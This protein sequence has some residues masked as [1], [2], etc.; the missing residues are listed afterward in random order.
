VLFATPRG[1][2]GTIA[3][4]RRYAMVV[5]VRK[6]FW[7][8]VVCVATVGLS[9]Q[10]SAIGYVDPDAANPSVH[11][12]HQ[13]SIL[14]D[15]VPG[16]STGDV[17]VDYYAFT[18]DP[19]PGYY[20]AYRVRNVS[21]SSAAG[22]PAALTYF[23]V[24]GIAPFI[25]LGD[26]G[27]KGTSGNYTP[28]LFIGDEIAGDSEWVGSVAAAILQG[29]ASPDVLDTAAM[30]EIHSVYAPAAGYF[31]LATASGG[32]YSGQN[33]GVYAPLVPE[34]G[35][36]VILAAGIGLLGLRVRRIGR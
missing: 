22:N 2:L 3:S 5:S 12:L 31:A 8:L 15:P 19:D 26:G 25:A 4:I 1:S 35:T 24:T 6:A 10:V 13:G 32:G 17:Y 27:G 16:I 34:P 9:V 30:F 18:F 29:D 14:L 36:I 23:G 11:I 21:G 33:I 20:Y 7:G 28:W